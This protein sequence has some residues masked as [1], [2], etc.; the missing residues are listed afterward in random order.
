MTTETAWPRT[1][2]VGGGIAGL[3]AAVALRRLGVPVEVAEQTPAFG[4][5]GSGVTIQA[6]AN[7]VLSALGITLGED[8]AVPI[9]SF[10]VIDEKGRPVLY[11]DAHEIMVDPPSVNV[12]RADLHRV[13]LEAAADVPLRPGVAVTGVTAIGDEVEVAFDD[14][15]SGRWDLVVGADGV[16]SAVRRALLGEAGCRTRY[17]GQTCWRFAI[18]APDLVPTTT[19]EQWAIGRRMGA[20]PLARGRI[21]VYL[22]ASAPPGTPGPGTSD[23]AALAERFGGHHEVL[24]KIL[25]RLDGVAIHHGDLVEHVDVSFGAGR[26][27]LIGDAAHAMTPNLGQ[28]AGSAIEDAGALAL[29]LLAHRDDPTAIAAGLDARRRARVTFMQKT[30]WRIGAMGHWRNPVARWLRNATLRMVPQSVSDK[31]TVQLWQPGLELAAA[32][33]EAGYPRPASAA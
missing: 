21:Y 9:G 27:V 18:E 32:L 10:T 25:E 3:S 23:P 28:G 31:Q 16:H 1:L 24:D 7:A 26:V 14:G 20:V 6:N 17:S 15:S 19:I 4:V 5:V 11:G 22:V 29:E 33:R 8:D 2:I 12:H 13:L 30:A